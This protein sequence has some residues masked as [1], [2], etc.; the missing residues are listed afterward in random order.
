MKKSVAKIIT[1]TAMLMLL[2]SCWIP[3]RDVSYAAFIDDLNAT[4]IQKRGMWDGCMLSNTMEAGPTSVRDTATLTIDSAM[5]TNPEYKSA[6]SFGQYYCQNLRAIFGD[7][8][9][10]SNVNIMGFKGD[11]IAY[12]AGM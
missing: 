6:Y 11:S 10:R 7:N 3:G 4:P 9:T 12:K 8:Y 2:A 5:A 1:Y